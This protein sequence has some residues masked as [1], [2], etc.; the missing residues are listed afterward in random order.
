MEC[1]FEQKNF[2]KKKTFCTLASL[3]SEVSSLSAVVMVDSF[4][5]YI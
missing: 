2:K 3:L 5:E 4:L 1:N